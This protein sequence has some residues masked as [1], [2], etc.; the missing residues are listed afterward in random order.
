MLAVL[1]LDDALWTATGVD[2]EGLAFDRRFLSWLDSDHNGRILCGEVRQAIQWLAACLRD[3]GLAFNG[4]SALRLDELRSDTAD[5]RALRQSAERIVSTLGACSQLGTCVEVDGSSSLDMAALDYCRTILKEQTVSQEGVLLPQVPG[6]P[7]LQA[8]LETVIQTVGGVPHPSGRPGVNLSELDEFMHDLAAR[9]A[10]LAEPAN[11]P[12]ILPLGADTAA[13]LADWERGKARLQA[14]FELDA[15]AAL[16]TEIGK[17][18]ATLAL[19][20]FRK[21]G[22]LEGASLQSASQAAL[23]QAPLAKVHGDGLL[24]LAEIR[25]PLMHKTLAR[26]LEIAES[27]LGLAPRPARKTSSASLSFDDFLAADL[28]LEPYRSWLAAEA[29]KQLAALPVDYLRELSSSRL[30]EAA[31]AL[32][33]EKGSAALAADDLAQ[34]ER[35]LLY[36]QLLVPFLNNFVVFPYLY[37]PAHPAAF[38]AGTFIADGR[39]FAFSVRVKDLA[40]HKL[41]ANYSRMYV[42]YLEVLVSGQPSYK[43]AVPVTSGSQG[44]LYKGKYGLFREPDGTERSARIIDIL[45]N[46]ISVGETL[47]MPFRKAYKALAG[48]IDEISRNAE[49][50]LA[51]STAERAEAALSKDLSL[52]QNPTEAA[53][54]AAPAAATAQALVSAGGGAGSQPANRRGTAGRS[55]GALNSGA[56]GG[57]LAGGSIAVA[58]L[59]SSFAFISKTFSEMSASSLLITLGSLL[60]VVLLPVLISALSKLAARDLAPLLEASGMAMNRRIRLSRSQARN[61]TVQPRALRRMALTGKAQ[62]KS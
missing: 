41:S 49:E 18:A 44:H 46:P 1:E 40:A 16:D 29:G 14:F 48:K 30:V 43:A 7:A 34:V 9:L 38:E 11:N 60:M 8:F 20:A 35:I 27:L 42:L 51:R 21:A 15:A 12:A 52:Q 23:Q 33:A 28:R 19:S 10:W 62:A 6:N 61:F 5:G 50:K 22:S 26:C 3:P 47:G 17:E 25:N 13:A 55:A 31:R 45:E 57:L 54:S 58:A 56:L 2:I 53:P 32:V 36:K 39:R 59:G 37:D 4:S 24:R